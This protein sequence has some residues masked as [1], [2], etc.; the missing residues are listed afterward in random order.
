M[1]ATASF[2]ADHLQAQ[3]GAQA[4]AQATTPHI[5]LETVGPDGWRTRLGPT[6]VATML[7]SNQSRA[8]W[9]P[10][11][12]P[13]LEMLNIIADDEEGLAAARDRILNYTGT[14]RIAATLNSEDPS[15]SNAVA[16]VLE[17]DGQTDLN[18][19]GADIRALME[20]SIPGGYT[21]LDV[22]GHKIK[23]RSLGSDAISAPMIT[24]QRVSLIAG[25]QEDMDRAMGLATHLHNRPRTIDKP[26]PG[27]PA[28]RITFMI[29][30]MLAAT[31][32][33]NRDELELNMLGADGIAKVEIALR[34]AGPFVEL[35]LDTT[36]HGKAKGVLAGLCGE[37]QGV[38][39]LSR[40]VPDQAAA[41]KV[42]RVNMQKI[43]GGILDAIES[44]GGFYQA[45]ECREDLNR[46]F[47]IDLSKDML[48]HMTDEVLFVGDPRSSSFELFEQ[49]AW[50]VAYRLKD[51]AAFRES[52]SIFLKKVFLTS[53]ETVQVDGVD[54]HNYDLFGLSLWIAVGNGVFSITAGADGQRSATALLQAAKRLQVDAGTSPAPSFK[55]IGR[56]MPPGHNGIAQLDLFAALNAVSAIGIESLLGFAGIET[57]VHMDPEDVK[58]QQQRVRELLDAHNLTVVRTATGFANNTLR[59]RLFW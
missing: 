4:R 29:P 36:F 23:V 10:R 21:E 54:L 32:T 8:I 18:A 43:Y 19:V 11:L 57:R 20:R 30:E 16:I 41:W 9:R 12:A 59:W 50:R 38:S 7:A 13:V 1:L 51:E 22:A 34:A 40:L 33:W 25:P 47:G 46:F 52:L 48:A 42:S 17:G 15:G 2:M 53:E 35:D 3:G 39:Q 37:E 28:L 24:Q 58:Q 44:P 26:R 6:N 5:I 31:K 27:S 49:S 14:I 45:G 55:D 56:Y